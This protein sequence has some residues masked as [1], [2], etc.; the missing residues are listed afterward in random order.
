[1]GELHL[2][3]L[4]ERLLREFRV[5]ANVGTPRVSYRQTIRSRAEGASTFEKHVGGRSHFARVRVLI[6]PDPAAVK[7]TLRSELRKDKVPLEFHPA[8]EEGAA[9]AIASGGVLG[10]TLT[11]LRACI[12]DAEF[13]PGESS[14]LAY[15]AAASAALEDALGRAGGIILE[16]FMRFEI[17]VPEEYYGGV[18]SDLSKRRASIEGVDLEHGIRTIRGVVPLAEVFGYPNTLRS[19]TQG[20][21]SISLEPESYRPVPEEV[22][23]RFDL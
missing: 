17:E 8:I 10:L 16:P 19:L 5:E 7:P 6:E 23:A 14:A 13:R 3:I 22:A 15:T 1:M 21:G 2:E 9:G 18:S 11:Q 20:R 4:R 12:V